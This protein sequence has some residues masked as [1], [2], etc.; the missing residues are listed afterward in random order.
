MNAPWQSGQPVDPALKENKGV[1]YSGC[2][3]FL[4]VLKRVFRYCR[5]SCGATLAALVLVWAVAAPSLGK[6]D[7]KEADRKEAGTALAAAALERGHWLPGPAESVDDLILL[8]RSTRSLPP[9]EASADEEAIA[10]LI[11]RRLELG[12]Y[13]RQRFD[14]DV[15]SRFLDRY[16]GSLDN[17]RLHFLQSDLEE[18]ERYRTRLDNLT[19][20]GK[21]GPS[22]EI[23]GRFLQ[24]IEERVAYVAELLRD[25]EFSFTGE[26][27]YQLDRRE[28]AFPKDEEE[29]RALWRQHLRYEVLE[30]LLNFKPDTETAAV[31][32][33]ES[34][35]GGDGSDA[36][37][38]LPAQSHSGLPPEV[39]KTMTRRYS[40]LLRTLSGF[41]GGDIFQIYMG[42][43]AHV[44]DPH[45]DYLGRSSLDNFAINM[46]LSL[47]GIGAVLQSED[48]YCKVRELRPGP[49][50]RSKQIKPGD[51]IV[52]VAQD[53]GEP[54]DV[55]D[56]KLSKVVDLIRGP[57]GSRVR[58]TIIPAN[59]TDPSERAE[60]ALI[61]DEI[62]L[63]DEEAKAKIIEIPTGE[64]DSIRIGMIDLPSFYASFTVAAPGSRASRPRPKSTTIDVAKLIDKLNEEAIQG[65]ILDLRHNGGG[66]LEE[67]IQLTGLFIRQGPVVQV[68]DSRGELTIE[69]DTHDGVL[70]DGPLVVLT[71]R[72]SAS[73]SEILAG[74]L[75]DY[76]RALIVGDS[77]THGKGT[78]QSLIQLQ[79]M[80]SYVLPESTNIPGALKITVR[81]FYRASG[82]STQ[83]RGVVP[84]IVLPSVNNYADIGEASLDDSLPWDT[85]PSADFVRE[86]RVAPVLDELRE[87]S[88]ARLAANPDFEYIR[89]DIALYQEYLADKSVSLNLETRRI[90]K[91]KKEARLE[92][93]KQERESRPSGE[94][95]VYEITLNQVGQPGLPAPL[96]IAAVKVGVEPIGAGTEDADDA[97]PAEKPPVLDVTLKETKRILLDL[98]ELAEPGPALVDRSRTASVPAR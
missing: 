32:A 6:S 87:R 51:R 94:E 66:S 48:G 3:T 44:Y 56:W 62:K 52:A 14:D 24:R 21:T 19:L 31:D 71:S 90:E 10:V 7:A 17:L 25:E 81:K 34:P 97:E 54:V 5:G 55:V 29:A 37:A 33:P 50:M 91:E 63:E 13:R 70:Y 47:F 39:I 42:A 35:D 89:E 22:R 93:R 75:Q 58:L 83:R 78:V 16:I 76:G 45:S 30:E 84:D 72:H 9:V 11:A 12:H 92:Q 88:N 64:S 98:I 95:K 59:A 53:D 68:R 82:E 27:R 96:P 18:F 46:N 38:V 60:V 36:T 85:I 79:P 8:E 28:A 57:K 77:S 2:A 74:A 4:P 40:R 69:E 23:F 80:L 15:S 26:D 1:N 67:A 73:A 65:L 20:D 61:R 41:D 49:A 86:N 43:L